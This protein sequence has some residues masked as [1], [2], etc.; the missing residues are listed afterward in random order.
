ML[1]RMGTTF[2]SQQA[3]QL[4]TQVMLNVAE[5]RAS[6]INFDKLYIRYFENDKFDFVYEE[7]GD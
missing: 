3:T 2:D 7:P 6:D 5:L 4:R 1:K